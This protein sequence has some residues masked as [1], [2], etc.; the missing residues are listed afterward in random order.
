MK[1]IL[2]HKDMLYRYKLN[3]FN[4]MFH[5]YSNI[6]NDYNLFVKELNKY[7]KTCKD[8]IFIQRCKI[9]KINRKNNIK[10]YKKILNTIIKIYF[11]QIYLSK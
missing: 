7:L 2:N 5:Q 4:F 11:K 8:K 3:K 6:V 1:M 9:Y 10:R